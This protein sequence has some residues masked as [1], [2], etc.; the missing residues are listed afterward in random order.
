MLTKELKY[1]QS[2]NSALKVSDSVKAKSKEYIK[3]YMSK[4]GGPYY[5]KDEEEDY[6]SILSK[7]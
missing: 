6:A 2:T 7:I 1:C 3:K 4:F 5:R